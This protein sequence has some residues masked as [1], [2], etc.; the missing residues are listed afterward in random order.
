MK[1]PQHRPT[2]ERN[3]LHPRNPHRAHYD[4]D[5]LIARCP[6]LAPFVSVGRGGRPSIDFA[7]PAAVKALNQALLADGYGIEHWDIPEGYLCPPIPGRADYLHHLADLLA[8]SNGGEIPR[9]RSVVGL[10]IGVGANCI[11]PIIGLRSY[12]WRFVG[13]DIDPVS[14]GSAQ[15][16]ADANPP[17][18]GSIE[19]RLQKHAGDIFNGI[20][21]P[22]ERFAFSLCNPPFH[23]SVEEASAGSRRKLSNLAK[24]KKGAT[25]TR[26][27]VDK[28][29]LNFGGQNAELWCP[30][31][32]AAFVRKMVEQS[33][34][35]A[36][37][38]L[39]FSSLIAKQANLPAVYQ[40]LQR[41]G[42]VEVRTIEMA[43]G[44]KRSRLVA[45]S[46]LDEA[47]RQAW[48]SGA[49]PQGGTR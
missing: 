28:P 20:I 1:P 22:T 33:A 38:C 19:C 31:G 35:F 44:Q 12:G 4:F 36:D 43:Q 29:Q 18:R 34:H 13:A 48:F 7:D 17:L 45:W 23:S 26:G 49:K 9:G 8:E 37:Q 15:L 25:V 6:P 39:W 21:K 24:G 42:V 46:F 16:I 3:G 30:G 5:R 11:Y 10:D 2:G 27:A 32:E 40:A 47:A 14:V 41:V